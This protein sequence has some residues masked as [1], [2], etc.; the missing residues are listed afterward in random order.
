[1]QGKSHVE[2]IQVNE[3]ILAKSKEERGFKFICYKDKS[4]QYSS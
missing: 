2:G 3:G 4:T 1:M